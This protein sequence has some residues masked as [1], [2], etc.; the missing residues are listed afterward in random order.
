VLC[1]IVGYPI[2]FFMTVAGRTS[3]AII[4]LC[5]IVPYFVSVIVRTYSWMVILG[6]NGVINSVLLYAGIT[7]SPISMMYNRYAIVIGMAYVMLPYMVLTLFATMRRIDGRF[8]R[9]G[10]SLGGSPIYVFRRVYLPLSSHAIFSGSVLVFMLCLGFYVTP[11]L[12]G[13]STNIMIS[14]LIV[15]RVDVEL[16]FRAAAILS[17]I[18]CASTILLYA[19]YARLS[20]LDSL[21][22]TGR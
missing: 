15:Q 17:L 22:E 20:R 21:L 3:L 12:M 16:N 7:S 14:M 18:L 19:I 11:A 6:K 1:L 10:L 8:V 5:I 13:A 4:S 2:A 9:A